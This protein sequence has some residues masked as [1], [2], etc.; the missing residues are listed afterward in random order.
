MLPEKT[1]LF[2]DLDGTLFDSRGTI[3]RENR[4]AIADY[5]ARGG[6]FAVS[7][8]R[9]P[10]N[11]LQYLKG[12]AINAPSVVL[13]G[14]AVYDFAA[15][16]YTHMKT[17]NRALL[18]P[19]L[20]RLMAEVPGLDLQVYT[21]AGIVY[22][23]PEERAQ[24]QL[25]SLHQPCR[26]AALD[27]LEGQPFIKSLLYAPPEHDGLLA[28]MLHA[29]EGNG[30]HCVPGTTD[31]GG[32]LTYYE[33]MPPGVSKGAALHTLRAHPALAG[34]ILLAAGD[35]WNDY[36]LLREADIPIA[37]ENAIPEIKALCS[38]CAVSNNNHAIR[39][40]LKNILP[41]L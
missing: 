12:V 17:L 25:K 10:A 9:E 32:K 3:S 34:R 31:I 33:L 20:R 14:A 38:H 8:G 40:V 16:A 28:E 6:L 13:N 2:S 5:T 29:A 21:P 7:T 26:F 11:A 4:E 24:P 15:G 1:V 18:D 37:P 19:L 22:C 35:Y 23:T 41:T 36:E 27:A 30:F 39:D